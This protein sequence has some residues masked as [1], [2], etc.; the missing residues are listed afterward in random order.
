MKTTSDEPE[1]EREE[2]SCVDDALAA[3]M[4]LLPS[5]NA[6]I[7]IS[8]Y[9]GNHKLFGKLD[10]DALV[11]SLAEGSELIWANDLRRPEA[12]LLS[13]A[14]SLQAIYTNLAHRA[15][16]T[17]E[18]I[19]C[20]ETFLRL[21]LRA[22]NQSRMTLE[23]LAT[24]KNPPVVI[25]RQAN[26]SNGP[27]QVNNTVAAAASGSSRAY[28]CECGGAASSNLQIKQTELLEV[29]DGKWM[30]SR[31]AGSA[32]SADSDVETVGAVHRPPHG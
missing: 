2:P 29:R 21:A 6:A 1:T 12:M 14:H 27:M 25:A 8:E 10:A 18:P 15:I 23:T 13:Q 30:D 22:Q 11:A 17:G 28:A 19:K 4:A 9:A 5:I 3:K 31:A 24:I 7:V 32:S 26:V 20:M 16:Q